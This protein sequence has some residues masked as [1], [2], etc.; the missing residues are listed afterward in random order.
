MAIQIKMVDFPMSTLVPHN[1]LLYPENANRSHNTSI[2]HLTASHSC[3]T[4]PFSKKYQRPHH[5]HLCSSRVNSSFK[6]LSITSP[7]CVPNMT[8]TVFFLLSGIFFCHFLF[9]VFYVFY[10]NPSLT[11]ANFL[12]CMTF[13][14][15]YFWIQSQ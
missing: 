11:P 6:I 9:I 3:Y 1:N 8:D 12:T 4:E 10:I 13:I 7:L 15:Y 14:V 2:T 5:S